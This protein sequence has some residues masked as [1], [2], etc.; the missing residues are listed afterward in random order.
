[1]RPDMLGKREAL[2]KEELESYMSEYH[3]LTAHLTRRQR[4]EHWA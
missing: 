2:H 3:P 1:M 4:E